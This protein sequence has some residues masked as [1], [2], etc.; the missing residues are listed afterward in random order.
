MRGPQAVALVDNSKVMEIPRAQPPVSWGTRKP[1][2]GG[3]W[4]DAE[5]K[6]RIERERRDDT[7]CCNSA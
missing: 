6:K 5:T 4:G 1:S 2:N 3:L 7:S